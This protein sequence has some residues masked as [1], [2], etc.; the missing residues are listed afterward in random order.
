MSVEVVCWHS[1][2]VLF[3]VRQESV[4]TVNSC[5]HPSAGRGVRNAE[6]PPLI[7]QRLQRKEGE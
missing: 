6:T 3:K 4:S 1:G 5:L 2:P 7:L